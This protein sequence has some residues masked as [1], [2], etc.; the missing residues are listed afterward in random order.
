MRYLLLSLLFASA[1]ACGGDPETTV[2]TTGTPGDFGTSTSAVILVNP[3]INQGSRTTVSPG[4]VRDGVE[5]GVEGTN[6]LSITD[7]AGIAVLSGLP[8]GDVTFDFGTGKLPVRIQQ[9]REMYDVVVALDAAGVRTIFDPVR[10]PIGGT[11]V[12]VA[13]GGDI[14]AAA[15]KDGTIILLAEGEYPGGFEVK[16]DGVLIFGAWSPTAGPLSVIEGDVTVR[17]GNVR[18]R[19]VSVTGT[20][21]A[22]ANGFSGAFN[23]F[24]GAEISGNGVTLLRNKFPTGGATVNVPSSNAVL[25]G[26]INLP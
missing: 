2:V 7:T 16:A 18:M 17:G 9:A 19:G 15:E 22:N 25:V 4:L 24:G 20:L 21:H 26:N 12:R 23:S 6:L 8:T 10:Y 13:P 5:I 14:A 1:A 3:R 11:R